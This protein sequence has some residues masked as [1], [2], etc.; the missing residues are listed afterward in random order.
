MGGNVKVQGLCR[1]TVNV[2]SMIMVPSFPVH[3]LAGDKK[4]DRKTNRGSQPTKSALP[5][6][7]QSFMSRT[8]NFS[9]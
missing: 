2:C 5:G 8:K 3:V 6:L 9:S 7:V 1:I 4:I